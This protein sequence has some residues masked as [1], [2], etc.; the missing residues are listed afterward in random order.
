MTNLKGV[1]K[2]FKNGSRIIRAFAVVVGGNASYKPEKSGI[3]GFQQ[4]RRGAEVVYL[5]YKVQLA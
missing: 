5:V 2:G 3:K 4:D 1:L